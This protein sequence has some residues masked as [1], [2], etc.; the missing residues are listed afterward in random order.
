M[1]G[2]FAGNT[3]TRCERCSRKKRSN[4]VGI[5]Y[6][7]YS[8]RIPNKLL[9]TYIRKRASSAPRTALC[10]LPLVVRKRPPTIVYLR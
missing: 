6:G 10:R 3:R 7:G 5:V 2:P 8:Y 4:V 1:S 9:M